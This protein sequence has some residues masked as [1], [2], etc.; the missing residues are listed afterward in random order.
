MTTDDTDAYIEAAARIQGLEVDP[1]WKPNVAR[2]FDV[3]RS[4]AKLVEDTGALTDAEG[5]P[6]FTP[7]GGA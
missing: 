3:A 5:A 4:M 6:V 1:A 7:R 2:F